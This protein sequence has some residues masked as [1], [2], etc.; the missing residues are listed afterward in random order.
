MF[1]VLLNIR[2]NVTTIIGTGLAYDAW[3]NRRTGK[4]CFPIIVSDAGQY[5]PNRNLLIQVAF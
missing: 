1:K 2:L 3:N 5:E 4:N